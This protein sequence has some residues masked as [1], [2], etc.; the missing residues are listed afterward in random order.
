[1]NQQ[2][3]VRYARDNA[4][5]NHDEHLEPP[6]ESGFTP[7]ENRSTPWEKPC[8]GTGMWTST[9]GEEGGWLEWCRMEDFMMVHPETKHSYFLLE[10]RDDVKVFEINKAK[11]LDRLLSDFEDREREGRPRPVLAERA[12]IDFEKMHRAGWDGVH[13]TVEGMEACRN[14]YREGGR[15]PEIWGWD[16]E[17]TC[18]LRWSFTSVVKLDNTEVIEKYGLQHCPSILDV[19]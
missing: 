12:K 5:G 3:W 19:I 15:L 14:R 10:V 16:C 4:P 6:T 8:H 9:Y 7:P 17:S 1:L 13:L 2:I 11:D 18:W